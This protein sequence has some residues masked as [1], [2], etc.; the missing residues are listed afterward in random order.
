MRNLGLRLDA[1]ET[2]ASEG[3]PT[4]DNR[5]NGRVHG[6]GHDL[7]RI[8]YEN[9]EDIEDENPHDDIT[10]KVKVDILNFDGTYD[11]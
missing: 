10:R 7:R 1:L 11:P 8:N 6:R 2:R 3:R 4:R 9:V 5:R